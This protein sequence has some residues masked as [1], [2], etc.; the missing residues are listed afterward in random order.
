MRRQGT[1]RRGILNRYILSNLAAFFGMALG[2]L[3]T[4]FLIFDFFDRIDNIIGERSNFLLI[5]E[6]FLLK[7]PYTVVLMM[8]VAVLIGTLMT[9]GLL[10]RNAELT[11]MR[12]AGITIAQVAR[13]IIAVGFL[14]S[15]V[16]L[17]LNEIVVP[18]ASRRARE[19][20]N[21]DI[22]QKHSNGAY[23][24][25]DF[26]WRSGDSFY[27]VGVFDSRT[28]TL[29]GFSR[30]D[31][32]DGMAV[33][34][35]IN[36]DTVSYLDS[37]LGWTMHQVTEYR[38]DP[39]TGSTNSS[40]LAHL[41]LPIDKEPE[42]FYYTET[43]PSTMSYRS[44]RHFIYEQQANGLSVDS[45][46]ADLYAKFSFP[47]ICFIM[48]LIIIPFALRPARSG[49]MASSI[50]AALCIGFGYYVVHSFAI[51]LGRAEF[52]PPLI[53]AWLG[54]IIMGAVGVILLAGSEQPL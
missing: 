54:N 28:S 42:D 17:T 38:F 5:I 47:F 35:R 6:Y 1:T 11:A 13:P 4:L 26:W 31:I 20:Y 29:S 21:I 12:S 3:T 23:S 16:N 40:R 52:V 33:N 41:P 34:S 15:L 51:S 36:A 14:L 18:Y 39:T 30:F 32:A 43:D 27:S 25:N 48:P 45:Y 53:A 49:S 9:I 8:P 44:L 19:I 24:Q 50:L 10:S 46:Y 7:V 2:V 22:K 37:L